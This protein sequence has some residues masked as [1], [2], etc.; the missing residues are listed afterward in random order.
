VVR[1]APVVQCAAQ[2]RRAIEAE[3][4]AKFSP[5]VWLPSS[6]RQAKRAFPQ[7]TAF[8]QPGS[9]GARQLPWHISSC[10]HGLPLR[11]ASGPSS[12]PRA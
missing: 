3:P 4:S 10:H 9:S 7:P 12:E 6:P 11:A 5:L 2:E 1:H 8:P